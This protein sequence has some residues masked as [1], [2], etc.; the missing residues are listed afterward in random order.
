[1]LKV[2]APETAYT[3]KGYEEEVTDN[4]ADLFAALPPHL[5]QRL[6]G[7]DNRALIELVLD[8]GRKPEARYEDHELALDEHDVTR[9][10]LE[11]VAERIGRFGED[12]RA[13]I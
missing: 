4:L 2:E 10:D 1:M 5:V 8:L 3:R 13:G 6:R 11:Y 9:A 12:N 7:A